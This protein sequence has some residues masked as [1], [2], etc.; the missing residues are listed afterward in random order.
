M[1]FLSYQTILSYQ[2]CALAYEE[3]KEEFVNQNVHF[4]HFSYF[5]KLKRIVVT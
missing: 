4:F 2:N 3:Q 1:I 5:I